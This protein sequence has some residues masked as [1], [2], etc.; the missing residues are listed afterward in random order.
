MIKFKST[1]ESISSSKKGTGSQWHD[2]AIEIY[3]ILPLDTLNQT[4]IKGKVLGA[5]VF[6]DT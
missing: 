5:H 3:K 2:V 4:H 6:D 1:N